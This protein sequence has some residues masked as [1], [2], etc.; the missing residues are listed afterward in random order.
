MNHFFI[1]FTRRLFALL[2]DLI[3]LMAALFIISWGALTIFPLG[4]AG[5]ILE[6][7]LA[8]FAFFIILVLPLCSFGQTLGKKITFLKVLTRQD[9]HLSLKKA[10]LREVV[11]KPVSS[12]FF[13]WGFWRIL[14]AKDK[15]TWHDL[16]LETKVVSSYHKKSKQRL[17]NEEDDSQLPPDTPL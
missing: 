4:L 10:M 2:I 13:F 15:L 6:V 1:I 17:T 8:L 5:D 12:L 16:L 11:L 14:L 9:Q 3:V 7:F